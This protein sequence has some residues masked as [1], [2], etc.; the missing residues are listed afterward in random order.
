ML[1]GFLPFPGLWLDNAHVK[2]VAPSPGAFIK[3]WYSCQRTRKAASFSPGAH[4]SC[5]SVTQRRT[6][7]TCLMEAADMQG[8]E[9]NGG[10]SAAAG[11][12]GASRGPRWLGPPVA[13]REDRRVFEAF[14]DE[15]QKYHLGEKGEPLASPCQRIWKLLWKHTGA[16]SMA[17]YMAKGKLRA[18]EARL[19]MRDGGGQT[20]HRP[21]RQMSNAWAV[22]PAAAHP[23]WC[24]RP[25]GL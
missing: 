7:P 19:F 18:A 12:G 20:V 23:G 10:E 5:A 6:G 14:E 13:E 17:A 4:P 15:G 22:V 1:A 3:T 2:L 25:C 9:R 24:M 8:N 16:V 21:H 11:R